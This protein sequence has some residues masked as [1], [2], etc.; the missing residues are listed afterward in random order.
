[1]M[2]RSCIH[3]SKRASKSE[4]HNLMFSH[5]K[6]RTRASFVISTALAATTVGGI[7]TPFTHAATGTWTATAGGSWAD[8]ANWAGGV[9]PGSTDGA[10]GASQD[11][12]LFN[13][14]G[15]GDGTETINDANRNLQSVEF[16]IAAA[17]NGRIIALPGSN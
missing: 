4:G 6:K 7:A 14:A 2:S 9:I 17:S 15:G 13:T 1:M 8:S 16:D 12:A 11:L 5:A 10:S 3:E